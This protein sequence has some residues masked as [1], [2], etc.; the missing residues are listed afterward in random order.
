MKWWNFTQ[1]MLLKLLRGFDYG[2]WNYKFFYWRYSGCRTWW[3][4]LFT[5]DEAVWPWKHCWAWWKASKAVGKRISEG[6][7][8][9]EAGTDKVENQ[10][11]VQEC[12]AFIQDKINNLKQ[13]KP[14]IIQAFMNICSGCS[15][16]Y[17]F[18]YTCNIELIYNFSLD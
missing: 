2:Q 17:A 9:V 12:Y 11:N 7:T 13:W 10:G 5:V 14:L 8:E 1:I 6:W 4:K 16:C 18:Y 15:R 3:W